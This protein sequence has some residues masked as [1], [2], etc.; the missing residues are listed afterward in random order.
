[1]FALLA[2]P[3][4][5]HDIVTKCRAF[6]LRSATSYRH[7]RADN[8]SASSLRWV[9]VLLFFAI[10]STFWE[11]PSGLLRSN[12]SRLGEP[13]FSGFIRRES[14]LRNISLK[15]PGQAARF[16]ITTTMGGWTFIWSIAAQPIFISRPHLCGTLSTE[17]IAMA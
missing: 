5:P 8:F 11:T 13:E 10:H 17:T 16:S 6:A 12:R 9:E 2:G 1:M 4:R 15:L 14:R 3:A 7:L